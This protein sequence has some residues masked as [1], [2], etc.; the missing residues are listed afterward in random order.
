[1]ILRHQLP[2]YSPL[3]GRTLLAGLR[4]AA[5]GPG[6]TGGA[7][8]RPTPEDEAARLLRQHFGCRDVLLTDSGTSALAL[9]LRTL[10]RGRPAALPAYGCF[11]IATAA[12]GAGVDVLLYDVAPD[13]LGPDLDSLRR[14][15]R[16][17]AGAVVVAHLFGIP[18]DVRQLRALAADAG[19]TVIEDAAQ[20]SGVE[21]AGGPAGAAGAVG[22]LSFGRGKG[23]AAGRGGALL[24]N[25]ADGAGAVE[26]ARTWLGAGGAGAAHVA[27]AAA[28]WLLARPVVYGIPAS[29]PFLGLGQTVLRPV[30][31]P[32]AMS[33]A[34]AAMLPLSWS[35]AAD[36]ARIRRRNAERLRRRLAP[37]ATLRIP[38]IAPTTRPGYLR[39]PVVPGPR[40]STGRGAPAPRLGILRG[41]PLPLGELPILARAWRN[42]EAALPGA[43]LLAERLLTLPTHSR[44]A[45][46]D[47]RAL[48][49]W[50]DAAG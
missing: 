28:Q 48:E 32:L 44:L 34:A 4:A 49:A 5:R 13:T 24:A 27:A 18:V 41:Y 23:V 43:R 29:L 17:G 8:L 19:A 21:V 40:G 37:G 35:L 12:A 31:P 33:R 38:R 10:A 7:A 26:E 50:I 14:V 6:P 46:P 30:A 2:A 11:D 15:L 22:V 36:E 42:R 20:A 45:E 3:A 1:M 47:L 16:D 25:T 39:L 9:A